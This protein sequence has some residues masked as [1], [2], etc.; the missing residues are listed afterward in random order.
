MRILYGV[1]STGNGH[2]NRSRE[3]LHALRER[4]LDVDVVF[5]GRNPTELWDVDDFKPYKAFHGL[6]FVVKDGKIHH[7]ETAIKQNIFRFIREVFSLDVK[8]YDIVITDFE[9]VSAWAA[10]LAGKKRLGIG[11][12]YAFSYNVP[13]SGRG[14][15]DRIIMSS[16]APAQIKIGLHWN[17]FG[18]PILPPVIKKME[19][20]KHIIPRKIL[21]YLAFE[22]LDEIK[23]MLKPF[24]DYDFF[25]YYNV[26]TP[27]DERNIHMRPFSRDGFLRDLHDCEGVIC[28]AGF[29]LPSEAIHLWKKI[30]VRPISG[31]FEQQSNALAMEELGLGMRMAE[32]SGKKVEEWINSPSPKNISFPQVAPVLA[33]WIENGKWDTL[34]D[35]SNKLW[36]ME[37]A[38]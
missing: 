7:F 29:E 30:L 20:A 13:V 11:H 12:Q 16:F 2:I 23:T 19:R 38:T 3:L 28:N 31:Q 36:K 37:N 34:A 22:K 21:V 27:S 33:E 25:I 10:I 1:Q 4:G 6:S 35:L 18:F 26:K 14:I 15:I 17:K 9:P 8:P 24:S 5:S 32:L